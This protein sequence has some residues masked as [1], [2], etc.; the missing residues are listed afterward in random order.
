MCWCCWKFILLCRY[1]SSCFSIVSTLSLLQRCQ[2]RFRSAPLILRAMW[3]FT[4]ARSMSSEPREVFLSPGLPTTDIITTYGTL[5]TARPSSASI[6]SWAL[7]LG[8]DWHFIKI[9]RVWPANGYLCRKI[10]MVAV[11]RG[12]KTLQPGT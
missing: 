10:P 3:L 4:V 12:G 7:V 6:L 2:Q 11:Q 1:L 5:K 9:C 8:P